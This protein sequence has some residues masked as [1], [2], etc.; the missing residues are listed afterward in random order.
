MVDGAAAPSELAGWRARSHDAAG[1]TFPTYAKGEGPGVIVIHELPGLTREV[2][3]FAEELVGAGY[4]VVL[5]HLFGQVAAT[6]NALTGA[7]A[8]AGVCVRREFTKLA[9]GVTTPLAGWLRSLAR[10]L[11][12]RTGGGVGA[13]GM[14]FT[15]GFALA[16]MLDDAV[17]APVVAQ[18]SVPF[19]V[20]SR[21][22]ADIN[23]SP[24]DADAMVARAAQGCAVLGLRYAGDPAVGTRFATLERLLGENFRHVDLPGLSHATLTLAR[25]QVAVDAVLEF[26]AERL[27][28]SS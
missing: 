2:I 25:S 11:A 6:E 3:A 21:R 8:F 22:R 13:L 1:Y 26:F 7:A 24:V 9:V 16:M 17:A 12:T 15:G 28:R 19:P 23:L 20:S 5:P 18:P 10:D 4:T 27:P 14:C